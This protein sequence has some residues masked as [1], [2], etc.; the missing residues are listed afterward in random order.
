MRI[1]DGFKKKECFLG[2]SFDKDQIIQ[3]IIEN[4]GNNCPGWKFFKIY[5]DSSFDE[6]TCD[7]VAV[8][9]DVIN[10][11]IRVK[12]NPFSEYKN[13]VESAYQ[14]VREVCISEDEIQDDSGQIYKRI[15]A[16]SAKELF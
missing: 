5:V 7:F 15:T 6:I 10:K 16:S 8:Y 1:F 4:R 3:D 13:I 11:E 14:I 2:D 12:S 9:T